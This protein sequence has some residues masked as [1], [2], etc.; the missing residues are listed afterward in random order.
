M[1]KHKIIWFCIILSFVMKNAY[2]LNIDKPDGKGKIVGIVIDSSSGAKVEYAGVS[3]YK[4]L[5][6]SLAGGIIT[7]DKGQFEIKQL[8]E[9]KYYMLI[10]FMGFATKK[11]DNLEINNKQSNI[12]LGKI[13]LFPSSKQL[14][15]VS[16]TGEKRLIEYK[17]D[18]KVINANSQLAAN[19]GTA[20][21]ILKNSP[22]VSVDNEDNVSM[23]GK[24]DFQVF[25]NGRP[26][27]LK[28]TDAL[29]Q[30][31]AAN[32]ENIEIITN[33]SASQDAEGTA[34]II[35]IITKKN[36]LKGSGAMISITSGTDRS[37]MDINLSHQLKKWTFTLG[38]KYMYYNVPV[39]FTENRTHY[40]KDSTL[41]INSLSTQ[42][43]T[44]KINGINWGVDFDLDK[45]NSFSLAINLGT[46]RHLHDFDTKY[47]Y[48]NS[49]NLSKQYSLSENDYE[50]GNQY[51]SGNL[52]YKHS[53]GKNHDLSTNFFYSVIDGDRGLDAFQYLSN[54]QQ[55]K[56]LTNKMTKS[57][58]SNLSQDIRFKIDYTK[59]VFKNLQL[60]TGI[61]VQIKPYDADMKFDNFNTANNQW[62]SDTLYTNDIIFDVNLYAAYLTLSGNLKKIEYK[63]GL[64]SEYYE[65]KFA[66]KNSNISYPYDQFDLFP[67]LH[68][69]YKQSE[70]NQYQISASRRV[71][72]PSSWFMYPVPD[73]SD[74][75]FLAVGNPD[76]KP[77]FINA[78]E[79]NYIHNF[80]KALLSFEI[81]HKWSEGSF[82]QR[83]TSDANGVIQQKTVNFGNENFTGAEAAINTDIYKWMSVNLSSSMYYAL[84]KTNFENVSKSIE[85]K[86]FNTRLNTTFIPFKNV[87]LQMALYYDAP[88]D[89]IQS[90]ISERFNGN[91]SIRKDFP[92]QKASLTFT[93]RNPIWGSKN[94]NDVIE[95]D[96]TSYTKT[97]MKAAYSITLSFRLNN[98]KRQKNAG[99]QL[100]V[101]EGS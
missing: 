95:N 46:W 50:I 57:N 62:N 91:I 67:T 37:S 31:P 27:V 19:G 96:F 73:F 4:M 39:D 60:E 17:L 43:H 2:T 32:I 14:K 53:F 93:A 13:A 34:G 88:F 99:E 25:V 55:E 15:E 83:A 30:I 35:N 97:E 63:L 77:E 47:D 49:L 81:F 94:Y 64:R 45:K 69:S 51:I 5:D 44:T 8:P 3:I 82:S 75:Y 80:K 18:K 56:L 11:I 66:F 23:R 10:Q 7:D 92:K 48:S 70:K 90:H 12:Q 24:T 29:K 84:I 89:Y 36:T 61:Q 101:G 52:F 16:I 71:N 68:L 58:E 79:F 40:L 42:Y 6:S 85:T 86:I 78:L 38:A 87:K 22:S 76:L 59:P 9:G 74:S 28:G 33:P 1:N 72:R 98:Y 20:I 100:N 26:S 65:R 54:Y 41:Y 21:D